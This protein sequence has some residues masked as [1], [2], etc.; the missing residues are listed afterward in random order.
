MTLNLLIVEW[1]G[2]EIASHPGTDSSWGTSLFD[3]FTFDIDNARVSQFALLPHFLALSCTFLQ[4][5]GALPSKSIYQNHVESY[6]WHSLAWLPS[7]NSLGREPYSHS[8][9]LFCNALHFLHFLHKKKQRIAVTA[10]FIPHPR[11]SEYN[12]GANKSYRETFQVSVLLVSLHNLASRLV[13]FY[14]S[15]ASKV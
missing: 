6:D 4:F 7:L 8:S 12:G 5:L 13:M 9:A 2:A 1:R 14:T 10:V 11:H 15:K 3:G